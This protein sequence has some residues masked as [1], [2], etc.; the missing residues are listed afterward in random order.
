MVTTRNPNTFAIVGDRIVT[1]STGDMLTIEFVDGA[2]HKIFGYAKKFAPDGPLPDFVR[3]ICTVESIRDDKIL[4]LTGFTKTTDA[5]ERILMVP[6]RAMSVRLAI[7]KTELA[8]EVAVPNIWNSVFGSAKQKE[9]P[10]CT[11]RNPEDFELEL[12]GQVK[13]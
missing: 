1:I 12:W 11:I 3:I 7:N 8:K 9:K 13:E 4:T 6:P 5:F 2:S 10:N